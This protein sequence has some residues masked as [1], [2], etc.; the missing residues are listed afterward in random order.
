MT[1]RLTALTIVTLLGASSAQPSSQPPPLLVTH[2]VYWN[3][4]LG[5][6]AL[7][8]V[9]TDTAAMAAVDGDLIRAARALAYG[10]KF[11]DRV[12]AALHRIPSDWRN[13]VGTHL[14]DASL[15]LS[16]AG[17][18]L[19]LYLAHGR[20]ADLRTAQDDEARASAELGA[21]TGEAKTA[22]ATMGGD[23]GDLES[24]PHA[25]QSANAAFA[26]AMGDTDT[27]DQ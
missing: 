27:D 25:M 10:E 7:I 11:V 12:T 24:L 1:R 19:R 6:F 3:T 16:A 5:D 14:S 15:A 4:T 18:A 8:S 21:A 23:A 13:S 17:Y 20:V 26:S 22:Y 9:C 2:R